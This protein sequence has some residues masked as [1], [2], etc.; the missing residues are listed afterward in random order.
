[1]YSRVWIH[2][3]KY[4][5]PGVA[6]SRVRPTRV[7]RILQYSTTKDE[8]ALESKSCLRV[9]GGS[10]TGPVNNHYGVDNLDAI[11][12]FVLINLLRR[13]MSTVELLQK[14]LMWRLA[15]E[16]IFTAIPRRKTFCAQQ[17][18]F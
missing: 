17:S 14:L 12:H 15:T 6:C 2:T 7:W 1:M 8:C 9:R 18:N 5:L 13:K 4:V 3:L 10:Y 11:I 16:V